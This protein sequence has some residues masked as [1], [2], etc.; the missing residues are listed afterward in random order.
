MSLEFSQK[1]REKQN[2][3]VSFARALSRIYRETHQFTSKF[4]KAIINTSLKKLARYVCT[5]LVSFIFF[6]LSGHT[7]KYNSTNTFPIRT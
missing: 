6:Q 7:Q 5:I 3:G 2:I 1:R 4:K